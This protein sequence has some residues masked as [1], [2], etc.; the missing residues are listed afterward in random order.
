MGRILGVICFMTADPNYRVTPD[1]AQLAE[2]LARR[3][4]IAIENALLHRAVV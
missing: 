3:A 1:D 4:A 2:D